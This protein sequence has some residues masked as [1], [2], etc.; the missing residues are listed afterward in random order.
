MRQFTDAFGNGVK[1][2]LGI[3]PAFTQTPGHVLVLT[4]FNR[5]WVLTSH[6]ERGYEFP[7]GKVEAGE[8]A[9]EAA[10]REVW[11]ETGG[12]TNHLVYIGQY[13]VTLNS[14][15]TF[16]KTIFAAE[17]EDIKD[18]KSYEETNG[19]VL[20]QELP[21]AITA[22]DRFSFIMKDDVVPMAVSFAIEQG[23]F[24]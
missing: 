9:E 12:I 4:R 8:Q 23:L 2:V 1:L 3:E 17:L 10:A 20:F 14:G 21:V 13:Q 5:E 7:G 11:E 15:K 19:P 16:W 24:K 22:D 18:R 6:Q